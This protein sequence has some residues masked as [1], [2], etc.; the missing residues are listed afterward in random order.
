MSEWDEDGKMARISDLFVLITCAV[1]LICLLMG[2][3]G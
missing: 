3:I 1:A 2:W